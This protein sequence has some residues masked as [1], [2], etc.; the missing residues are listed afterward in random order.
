MAA[1]KEI[2]AQVELVWVI[3]NLIGSFTWMRSESFVHKL[4]NFRRTLRAAAWARCANFKRS[5]WVF[6]W[7]ISSTRISWSGRERPFRSCPMG[8]PST[9]L[10]T[11]FIWPG[12][13]S[14]SYGRVSAQFASGGHFK[15]SFVPP[16]MWLWRASITE[17]FAWRWSVGLKGLLFFSF[18]FLVPMRANFSFGNAMKIEIDK[19]TF[20]VYC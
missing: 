4:L 1:W 7:S 9:W 11:S 14:T 15:R 2:P 17:S 6:W 10:R 20:K 8:R 18:P 16:M 19:L 5:F 3:K 13:S 12:E